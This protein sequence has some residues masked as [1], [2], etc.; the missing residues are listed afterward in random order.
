MSLLS[1]DVIGI[2]LVGYVS[3]EH[4]DFLHDAIAEFLY[5]S[6][7][8]HVFWDNEAFLRYDPGIRDA[9]VQLLHRE[10]SRWE[11]MYVLFDSPFIGMTTTAAGLIL[12]RRI[13]R[14][15]SRAV[16]MAAVEAAL[17]PGPTP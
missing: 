11:Q 16:F 2:E 10:R 6:G 3:N 4:A 9:I 13:Y 5:Q 14:Y 12:G 8:A 15:R 7:A 17:V 1:E